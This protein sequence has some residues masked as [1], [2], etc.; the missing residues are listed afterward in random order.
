MPRILPR[1]YYEHAAIGRAALAAL[2]IGP[3]QIAAGLTCTSFLGAQMEAASTLEITALAAAKNATRSGKHWRRTFT[4]VPG[5]CWVKLIADEWVVPAVCTL[6]AYPAVTDIAKLAGYFRALEAGSLTIYRSHL[7]KGESVLHVT[8]THKPAR[9]QPEDRLRDLGGVVGSRY[10]PGPSRDTDRRPPLTHPSRRAQ[11]PPAPRQG[12][13]SRSQHRGPRQATSPSPYTPYPAQKPA[14]KRPNYTPQVWQKANRDD[15]DV[16]V[17]ALRDSLRSTPRATADSVWQAF[18]SWLA[19]LRADPGFDRAAAI[20]LMEA[21]FA[22]IHQ[23]VVAT[24]ESADTRETDINQ[25]T[26]ELASTVKRIDTILATLADPFP[27]PGTDPAALKAELGSLRPRAD[28]LE[29]AL[30]RMETATEPPLTVLDEALEYQGARPYIPA[31]DAP[32]DP[33]PLPN[34]DSWKESNYKRFAERTVLCFPPPVGK[35][36]LESLLT[37]MDEP[38]NLKIMLPR[39]LELYSVEELKRAKKD[40]SASD[41]LNRHADPIEPFKCWSTDEFTRVYNSPGFHFLFARVA[42]IGAQSWDAKLPALQKMLSA[43]WETPVKFETIPPCQDWMLCT[44]PSS[45]GVTPDGKAAEILTTSLIRITEGNASYVVR[46]LTPPSV[47]RDLEFTVPSTGATNDGIFTQL[48]K[49]QLEFEADG[50]A[51]GWRVLGVRQAN[52]PNKFRGT[53]LLEKPTSYWPWTY[54]WKHPMGSIPAATPLLNFDPTWPARKPYACAVCYSSDHAVYECPLPNMRIGG[55]AIVSAMSVALVSNKKAQE[56]ILV[57]DR[58]LKP[59]PQTNPTAA[60]APAAPTTTAPAAPVQPTTPPPLAAI[61]EESPRPERAPLAPHLTS[62]RAPEIAEFISWMAENA[63][64]CIPHLDKAAVLAA[65]ERNTGG[66]MAVCTDLLRE[67]FPVR[68]TAVDVMSRWGQWVRGEI[69]Y[70]PG[71]G[72]QADTNTSETPFGKP[73]KGTHMATPWL[74]SVRPGA[75]QTPGKPPSDAVSMISVASE[76]LRSLDAAPEVAQRQFR[77]QLAQ[78]A[79]LFPESTKSYLEEILLRVEGDLERA[80]T[81]MLAPHSPYHKK[82]PAPYAATERP[83]TPDFSY[84]GNPWL[85][86]TSLGAIPPATPPAPQLSPRARALAVVIAAPTQPERED[87]PMEEAAPAPDL[88]APAPAEPES[89]PGSPLTPWNPTQEDAAVQC[90]TV[91][92][93]RAFPGLSDEFVLQAM[94]EGGGDPAATIAWA[95]AITDADRV[96]GIMADAFPTASPGEVKDALLANHGN[97][98]AAYTFLSHQHEST[99]DQ[100]HF[101]LSSQVAWKLLPADEALAPEFRDRDPSY[102]WHEDKWWDTMIATKAYKVAGSAPDSATWSIVSLLAAGTADI[103][104]RIAGYVESLGAQHNDKSA[105]DT[106]MKYLQVFSDFGALNHFCSTN[107]KQQE[108]A[109]T[110]VLALLEDGIASLGAA[111]WAMTQ[112][113]RSPM[114]Y[115]ANRLHFSAYSANRRTLWNRRNQSLAAWKATR[116]LPEADIPLPE[117]A[118]ASLASSPAPAPPARAPVETEAAS[119][120]TTLK[121]AH[122]CSLPGASGWALPMSAS[123]SKYVDLAARPSTRQTRSASASSAGDPL[124]GQS[125]P[126]LLRVKKKKTATGKN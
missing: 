103:S 50:V 93:R 39:P 98:T 59:A 78:L 28:A 26:M 38:A 13:S 74:T 71:A 123:T 122:P 96:L 36:P 83:P 70:R 6:G 80:V 67:G 46:H 65:A 48:K 101:C 53:F 42:Q 24:A 119:A 125:D 97:A 34:P 51:L 22:E 57:V 30:D 10:P 60:P 89:E 11:V 23:G 76:L 88:V 124:E 113:S 91:Y 73:H 40:W 17:N 107:P 95:T 21:K 54:G 92:L 15:F 79:T 109:L 27:P 32:A 118:D 2:H 108:S 105:S 63:P 4:R 66:P 87:T 20:P 43:R 18:L 44:I 49:R 19:G 111:A 25:Q 117:G 85:A 16:A 3:A 82:A 126:G 115:H 72:S 86:G 75:Q 37:Q 56:R 121:S 77:D 102:T 58:S 29:K 106:A 35:V 81:V 9:H 62:A 5:F 84:P 64:P 104:P 12:V 8:G 14:Q 1:R 47:V 55:V 45:D 90:D 52:A 100:E 99:W 120:A 69:P 33:R 31:G 61:P 114:A 94:E 68:W 41:W 116:N 110:I 112:L 7:R